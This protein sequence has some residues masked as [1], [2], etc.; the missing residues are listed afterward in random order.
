[1]STLSLPLCALGDTLL[2]EDT[3]QK[4]SPIVRETLLGLLGPGVVLSSTTDPSHRAALR[5]VGPQTVQPHMP[6][7]WGTGAG[8]SGMM[9]QHKGVSSGSLSHPNSQQVTSQG[10]L[11]PPSVQETSK[12]LIPAPHIF[13]RAFGIKTLELF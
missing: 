4:Q 2:P 8:A 6:Q 11:C 3:V 12:S 10:H 5:E 9:L 7:S 13:T 1:M